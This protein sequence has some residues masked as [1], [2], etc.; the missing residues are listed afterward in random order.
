[1]LEGAVKCVG[2]AVDVAI[3]MTIFSGWEGADALTDPVVPTAIRFEFTLLIS[4][5]GGFCGTEPPP[6]TILERPET[7]CGCN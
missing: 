6:M 5:V 1:M 3:G 2:W 7:T 4:W